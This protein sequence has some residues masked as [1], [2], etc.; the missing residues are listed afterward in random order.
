MSEFGRGFTYCL[1]MFLAHQHLF[2]DKNGTALDEF[3]GMI[4]FSG[5]SDH[6]YELEIP[7]QFILKKECEEWRERCLYFRN[8]LRNDVK[9][10]DVTWALDKCREFLMAWDKQCGVNI[11]KADYQ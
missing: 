4:W 5:A 1:A 8:A 2:R 6:L 11:E 10:E 7:D 9:E 3:H